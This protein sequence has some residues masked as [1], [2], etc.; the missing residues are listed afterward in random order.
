M[1]AGS[2]SSASEAASLFQEDEAPQP[3]TQPVN[4]Q[5]PMAAVESGG[6]A[7][8][9]GVSVAPP[10]VDEEKVVEEQV[11]E[12]QIVAVDQIMQCVCESCGAGFEI[13]LPAGIPQAVVACPSCQVDNIVRA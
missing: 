7:L 2:L 9:Q 8:P 4:N 12:E 11:I 3:T 5:A 10:A 6:I 13:T 1:S